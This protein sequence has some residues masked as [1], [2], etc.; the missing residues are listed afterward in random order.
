MSPDDI[1]KITLELSEKLGPVFGIDFDIDS[2]YNIL[3]AAVDKILDPFVTR[4]R[5]YN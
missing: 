2:N 4:D 5:N 1:D 3:H